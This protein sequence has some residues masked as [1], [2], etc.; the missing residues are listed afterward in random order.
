MVLNLGKSAALLMGMT[1]SFAAP[2]MAKALIDAE[3]SG[4]V[5]FRSVAFSAC[6]EKAVCT[7]GDITISAQR[8]ETDD[9]TSNW[10]DAQIYWDPVDGLGVRDGAQ[11]D[12]I[13]FNEQL[14]IAFAKDVV[15]KKIW[16]S[17]L[18]HTEDNRYNS[19]DTDRVEGVAEDSEVAGISIQSGENPASVVLV[20]AKDRLPW[21]SFNQEISVR[22][23]E[24]G[25]LRRRVVID[26]ELVEIVAPGEDG[27]GRVTAQRFKIADIDPEKKSIFDNVETVEIDLTDI[28][29]EFNGTR[30]FEQGNKNF[31]I[32]QA[33]ASDPESLESMRMTAQTKRETI[34]MSNGEVPWT[35][36]N[37]S[38]AST[39][40]FFAPFDSS[41]DFSISGLVLE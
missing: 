3:L 21:A 17:D 24:G 22:F 16:F 40:T 41:N 32:I 28:L 33:L 20:E 34:R 7:V 29:A 8:R 6:Q 15:V 18:F 26:G 12:E 4:Q 14:S 2:A 30:L 5:D 31:E 13:D 1:A 37:G 10:V 39:V 35:F 38:A 25:D 11:N 23:R 9:S 27:R 36:E 19:G